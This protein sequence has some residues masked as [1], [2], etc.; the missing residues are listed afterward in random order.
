MKNCLYLLVIFILSSA[1]GTGMKLSQKEIVSIEQVQKQQFKNEAVYT[2]GHNF[3]ANRTGIL[4]HFEL[5]DRS[6]DSVGLVFNSDHVEVLFTDSTGFHSKTFQGEFTKKGVFEVYLYK[7]KKSIP[8][9]IP[10]FYGSRNIKRLR[11]AI[12][13]NHELVIDQFWARDANWFIVAAGG[14]GRF[15]SVYR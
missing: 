4:D 1:C 14:S 11:L 13:T 15:Q 6:A 10:I 12:N 8:P 5:Y 2:K 3:N 9:F 7:Q